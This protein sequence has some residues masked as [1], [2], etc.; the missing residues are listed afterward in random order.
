MNRMYIFFLMVVG[1]CACGRGRYYNKEKW[2]VPWWL[3]YYRLK[4]SPRMVREYLFEATSDTGQRMKDTTSL[5]FYTFNRQGDVVSRRMVFGDFMTTVA[6]LRYDDNGTE[7]K[8]WLYRR[9]G[10]DTFWNGNRALGGGWFKSYSS[11]PEKGAMTWLTR[12]QK[13]GNE[14]TSKGYADSNAVGKPERE[15]YSFYQGQRLLKRIVWDADGLLE[16]RYF[17][18]A[19][20]S[21]DSVEWIAG[22]Q[23]AQR[24]IFR[25][26]S[27]GDP[28]LY[29]KI[30]DRDTVEFRA[31]R[32]AYDGRGN[33]T[34]RRD[35]SR[36]E[37]V[38]W[39]REIVY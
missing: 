31:F 4:D 7:M 8:N 27:W 32:Y 2:Q 6:V 29:L 15:I 10:S 28:E 11:H 33:W 25:N 18:S 34:S 39:E 22:R 26:N 13:E 21:P 17:Y 24:E 20:D 1:L 36:K 19:S 5:T 38:I 3:S 12:F 9:G 35:S 23:V 14:Q 37:V 30:R 16:Q